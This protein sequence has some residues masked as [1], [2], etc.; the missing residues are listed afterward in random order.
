MEDEVKKPKKFKTLKEKEED[1]RL[2]VIIEK[3]S[4]ETVKVALLLLFAQIALISPAA[5]EVNST[6]VS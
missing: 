3:A 6:V 2:I 1:K 4:L 5:R